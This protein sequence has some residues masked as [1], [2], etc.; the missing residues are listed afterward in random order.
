M[1][2]LITSVFLMILYPCCSPNTSNTENKINQITVEEY[3]A[4]SGKPALYIHLSNDG[5]TFKRKVKDG[6]DSFLVN[7]YCYPEIDSLSL[8]QNETVF[9]QN[10]LSIGG[11]N[12]SDYFRIMLKNTYQ[13]PEY[14]CID[15][16][17]KGIDIWDTIYLQSISNFCMSTNLTQ[18]NLQNNTEYIISWNND[19]IDKYA[20]KVMTIAI[21]N[22]RHGAE[23]YRSYPNISNYKDGEGTP[24]EG[25]RYWHL[26]FSPE[27]NNFKLVTGQE[28]YP[29][30]LTEICIKSYAEYDI[31]A[32]VLCSFN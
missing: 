1:R 7:S 6:I 30:V 12:N 14:L 25:Y 13:Y 20:I 31:R 17:F 4:Y 24:P 8:N 11:L 32:Y 15:Y 21:D 3:I 23:Y 5:I 9:C 2:L 29:F 26:A 16:T 28:T 18:N 27:D 22:G 19:I 10:S